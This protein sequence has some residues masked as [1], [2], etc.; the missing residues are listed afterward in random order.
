MNHNYEAVYNNIHIRP[1]KYDDIE[2]LRSW[3]ND[4][5]ATRF[6][7][8]VGY[9]TSDM[10]ERWYENYLLNPSEICFAVEETSELKRMVGSVSLY[11]I[12]HDIAEV[13]KILIGDPEA[14]GR[15]IG[16][17]CLVMTM[18]IGFDKLGLQK[19]IGVVN[20]EN[21]AAHKNDMS[22]GFRIVGA[23]P[24]IVGG[25]EDEIEIDRDSLLKTNEYAKNIIVFQEDV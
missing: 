12:D 13:G 4:T 3:R 25:V 21:I 9:I 2:N 1:L 20:Q 5:E 6:L 14:H 8:H 23:H 11:N 10:Q 17:K 22:V 19:I 18:L 16:R 7:R 15:G 24:S